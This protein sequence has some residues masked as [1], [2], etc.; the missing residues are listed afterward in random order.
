LYTLLSEHTRSRR[1]ALVRQIRH[2]K[3]IPRIWAAV[4]AFSNKPGISPRGMFS[5][6]SL[7]PELLA[8]Q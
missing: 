7:R 8:S 4:D 6:A 3:R 2:Y 1:V 5:V